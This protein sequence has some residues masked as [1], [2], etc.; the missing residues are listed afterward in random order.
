MKAAVK[1]DEEPEVQP[2][3]EDLVLRHE[4]FGLTQEE[5]A[6]QIA[7]L[8]AY[9]IDKRVTYKAYA[10]SP[11]HPAPVGTLVALLPIAEGEW[12]KFHKPISGSNVSF[13]GQI[14]NWVEARVKWEF[15][16]K[17]RFKPSK[18]MG[19]AGLKLVD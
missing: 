5:A 18:I 3:I 6:E 15:N 19:L 17:R 10:A 4:F 14:S 11:D 7:E 13:S 1:I 2:D 8:K 16:P 12:V 9:W